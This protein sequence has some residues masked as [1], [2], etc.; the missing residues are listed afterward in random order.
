VNCVLAL[1]SY[2]EGKL[3]GRSGSGSLKYGQKP[4]T[5]GKPILRKNSEPFMK[6]LWSM[7][8]GDKDGYT[9]DPDRHEGVRE[10]F[11]VYKYFFVK[12]V[13]IICLSFMNLYVQGSFSSLNSLV[14][15]YLS[16]KKPE[17]IPIVRPFSSLIDSDETTNHFVNSLE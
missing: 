6:S 4:P 1:K 10:N 8:L 9:S 17:E 15:Q 7:T 2:A 14:R 16:D 13:K 12:M 3:V 11:I 5:S